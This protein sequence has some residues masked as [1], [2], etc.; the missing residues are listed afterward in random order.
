MKQYN[1]EVLIYLSSIKKF[2]ETNKEARDYF[3][4][5]S[6]P[7]VFYD[8]VSE[9]AEKNYEKNGAPELSQEEFEKIRKELTPPSKFPS[10][11]MFFNGFSLN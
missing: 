11:K 7:E 6:D 5:F 10:G 3:V 1:P 9:V 4:S 8:K 2:I